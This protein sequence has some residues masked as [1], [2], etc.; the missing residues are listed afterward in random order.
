VVPPVLLPSQPAQLAVAP[1]PPPARAKLDAWSAG[2]AAWVAG[3]LLGLAPI[4]LGVASLHRLERGSRRETAASWLDLLRQLLTRLR[5]Q[6]RV[7][8]LKAERRRMPMTWGVWRPK[9]L[10]PE[11]SGEWPADRR[12]VVLLHELAH[13][14][15]CDYLTQLA[16]RLV[17]ALYW[18]NP[19]VWLAARRMV[20][21][22]ERACDD[23]VLGHGAKPADYAEQILE[24]SAGLSTGWLAGCGGIAMARPSNLESRLR[25][26][27]DATHNRA[28][29]TRAAVLS[30]LL[31]LTA[32]LVPVAMMKAAP[33][34]QPANPQS[35]IGNPQ[36]KA[37]LAPTVTN[38]IQYAAGFV[39]EKSEIAVGE[40]IYLAFK[41]TNTSSRTILLLVAADQWYLSGPYKILAFDAK[42]ECL[43]NPYSNGVYSSEGPIGAAAIEPGGVYTDRIY[44]PT[45]VKFEKSG[46]YTVAAS[47]Q[48]SLCE[49]AVPFSETEHG[50]IFSS[51]GSRSNGVSVINGNDFATVFQERRFSGT[52]FTNEFKLTVRDA[53]APQAP[54]GNPEDV[55][56]RQTN[57]GSSGRQG[58]PSQP[59]ASQ[60][61][62][63]NSSQ[64]FAGSASPNSQLAAPEPG[65][66]GSA[67]RNPQ[68]GW[69]DPVEGV[70]V[71]LSAEGAV[72]DFQQ[73]GFFKFSVRN[74]GRQSVAVWRSQAEGEL[75]MDGVWYRWSQPVDASTSVLASGGQFD[76]LALTVGGEWR[77]DANFLAAD[78]GKHTLRFAIPAQLESGGAWI[79]VVSNPLDV[80][81]RW[82]A[83]A[84]NP[85][86]TFVPGD[87][88]VI[89]DIGGS[90]A[91]DETGAPLTNF[92]VQEGMADLAKTN[93]IL[94]SQSFWGG[95]MSGPQR[96]EFHVQGRKQG[97][98]W[99][100][101]ADGYLPQMVMEHPLAGAI[102][103]SSLVVRLKRGGELR[104][105]V[106]SDA[107]APVAGAQV[108]IQ[109]AGSSFTPGSSWRDIGVLSAITDATGHFSLRGTDGTAQKV[110]VTSSDGQMIQPA[111]Q[112]APGQEMKIALP[113]P[114]TLIVRYD[115]P[116]DT[117][118]ADLSLQLLTREKEMP[119]WNEVAADLSPVVANRGQIVLTNLTPGAYQFSRERT[120]RAGVWQGWPSDRRTVVLES[121]ETRQ[122]NLVR[123]IGQR[124]RGEVT[125]L[126]KTQATN[127]CLFIRSE[128]DTNAM[129][130]V[131]MCF[132][133]L[134]FGKD[135]LFQTALLEP[136]TYTV[137]AE[138]YEPE[139][140]SGT[141]HTG[142]RTGILLPDYV[143]MA[144]VTITT[145]AAP[146]SVKVELLPRASA[147]NP[148]AAQPP[149]SRV[150]GAPSPAAFEIP[151]SNSIQV[152]A[153]SASANPQSAIRNPQSD[154]GDAVE[155]VSLR[156]RAERAR[157][158][159]NEIVAL[160]FDARN[161]GTRDFTV[162]QLQEQGRIEVDGV[163]HDWFGAAG[164]SWQPSLL[165]PGRI[166]EGIPV[167]LTTEWRAKQ[168]NGRAPLPLWL[169][170]GKHTLRFSLAAMDA[171]LPGAKTKALGTNSTNQEVR[172]VSNPVEIEIAASNDAPGP[173]GPPWGTPVSG[174][175]VQLRSD[176]FAWTLDEVVTLKAAA[177]NQGPG[178]FSM[179][180]AQE[181][182]EVELDGIWY[183]WTGPF[184]IISPP[185]PPGRQYNDIRISLD[186][187]WRTKEGW[188]LA[189]PVPPS[190]RLTPGR[191]T[192]RFAMIAEPADPDR[193]NARTRAVSNP[194]QIE[195]APGLGEGAALLR[196]FLSGYE[197]QAVRRSSPA[198]DSVNYITYDG[199][200]IELHDRVPARE[201]AAE[202]LLTPAGVEMDPAAARA[203]WRGVACILPPANAPSPI[204][205]PPPGPVFCWR[206]PQLTALLSSRKLKIA[207]ANEAEEITRLILGLFKGWTSFENW[208]FETERWENWWLVT[209]RYAGPPAQIMFQGS[210]ELIEED[211]A[212]MDA[213]EGGDT[214]A[215]YHHPANAAEMG[216]G[217]PA[218]GFAL[219]LQSDKPVWYL[220]GESPGF[221]LSLRNLGSESLSVPDSEELG[222]LEMDGV[223]YAWCD[224]YYGPDE[225]LFP[226]QQVDNLAVFPISGWGK[227]PK[228]LPAGAGK[229]TIRFAFTA[230]RGQPGSRHAIRAVSN[231][232]E[233]EFR[234][235][236]AP[237]EADH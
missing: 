214:F 51:D 71:R 98:A 122:V 20:V 109:R 57:S 33:S 217:G 16:A 184:D 1:A 155:G 126:E 121:G 169:A 137:V 161:L 61:L 164:Y 141:I 42:G 25:A 199:P 178:A 91:D 147:T 212:L 83:S 206:N 183:S 224:K 220:A 3:V 9:V 152:L 43:P 134:T 213:R 159:S 186:R 119:L 111:L 93:D 88:P 127:G 237:K 173:A 48:I 151:S 22:R 142:I 63:V 150:D 136:G 149:Q 125:G 100:V 190:L 13:A 86:I 129:G 12:G 2:L 14:K 81:F 196:R 37:A 167:E 201:S 232:I 19:L 120:L 145:N 11:E 231:P 157:W 15:R 170:P 216:W 101:L 185:F 49:V 198:R 168:E 79:R 218:E 179:A 130:W 26:I 225:P 112:S 69:G 44:L 55:D 146:P 158:G 95:I 204:P 187:Y 85:S 138:A 143:G 39:P 7:V 96:G 34:P 70:S 36:S 165:P 113:K 6:R 219:R 65:E 8:L 105:V 29:L 175:S 110:V 162:S 192:V 166:Y 221:R 228:L 23:I 135:G 195:V 38:S 235:G 205:L 153:T 24:I 139:V 103:T 114:A 80:E 27:L 181:L 132:D 10:L 180:Q 4:V 78:A 148:R 17:C 207:T 53:F 194:V 197:L 50:R 236:V 72:W 84:T 62:S 133:A 46:E 97:Q 124:L 92:W 41:L 77:K 160:T 21:E 59:A 222:E 202:L 115:I 226:G 52:L 74:Q 64:V 210:V 171:N 73:R 18:F 108:A 163:W 76:G 47:R 117:E 154:W 106:L 54:R 176:H 177:R 58:T 211:G 28:T 87:L 32:I 229:H 227:D 118:Q 188:E 123:S 104:G 116:G 89:A 82:P 45:F 66:G 172:P 215:F 174:V 233:V 140:H 75:E 191:H 234:F 203:A 200:R 5:F 68:S 156:L 30:A 56:R 67:I 107:G 182:G 35:A 208:S 128:N 31:L 193:G 189:P 131:A 230:R 94:W 209:P 102:Q 60:V 90:V 99:R 144:K 40:P 223:W